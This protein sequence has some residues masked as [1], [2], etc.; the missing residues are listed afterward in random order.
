MATIAGVAAGVPGGQPRINVALLIAPLG[1]TIFGFMAAR[2]VVTPEIPINAIVARVINALYILTVFAAL[3]FSSLI[4]R[5]LIF[6]DDQHLPSG[7]VAWLVYISMLLS[8]F[9]ILLAHIVYSGGITQS[10][11]SG[12]LTSLPAYFFVVLI[13]VEKRKFTI[14]IILALLVI[15][16]CDFWMVFLPDVISSDPASVG[17]FAKT[18]AY[19][20]LYFFVYSGAM[21][22][23]WYSIYISVRSDS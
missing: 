12:L 9:V 22:W 11:F 7:R 16:L 3:G 15:L 2:A 17:A 5:G 4:V 14:P 13:A 18:S 1:L 20:W 21:I 6:P 10:P 19:Y 8:F 23:N